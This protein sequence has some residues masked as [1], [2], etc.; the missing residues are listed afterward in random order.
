[1]KKGAIFDLDGTMVDTAR[2][3]DKA[4]DQLFLQYNIK[5]SEA[6]M[7]EHR[8][9]KNVTFAA[10]ILSRR[11]AE[12]LKAKDLAKEKDR[13]VLEAL[14]L[15]AP[16][17]FP[18]LIEFLKLLK[19]KGIKLALAT[20]ATKETAL[21]L[22]QDVLAYFEV[23]VFAE[24]TD[25]G[26]PDPAIFLLAAERM[27]LAVLDCMV[28]EDSENGVEAAKRGGLFCVAKDNRAGQYLTKADLIIAGYGREDVQRALSS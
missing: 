2:I 26:K 27:N 8:G 7:A 19:G 16:A 9:K 21:L 11:H 10:S 24:D 13:I 4:W 1:M 17:V 15:K 23:A 6:E 3:H 12:H 22:A 14:S 18:G 5:L 25:K 20:S 28:F